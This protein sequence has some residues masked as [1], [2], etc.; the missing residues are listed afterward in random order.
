MPGFVCARVCDR[1]CVGVYKGFWGSLE[2]YSGF[3][4]MV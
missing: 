3:P 1:V 2:V 4:Q